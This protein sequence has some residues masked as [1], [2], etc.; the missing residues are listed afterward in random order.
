[1]TVDARFQ[2]ERL[3]T[4]AF[5]IAASWFR[6]RTLAVKNSFK[7]RQ[8]SSNEAK[9]DSYVPGLIEVREGPTKP[10]P[11]LHHLYINALQ[12]EP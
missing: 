10:S 1:M 11:E 3:F 12:D 2:A 4:S 7:A 6:P 9:Y 5:R 8:S